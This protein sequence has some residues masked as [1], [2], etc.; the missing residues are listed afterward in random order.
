MGWYNTRRRREGFRDHHVGETMKDMSIEEAKEKL[1]PSEY[2]KW[3]HRK[4]EKVL[5]RAEKHKE[6][7][8]DEHEQATN[9]LIDAGKSALTTTCT[10]EGVDFELD[11]SFKDELQDKLKRLAELSKSEPS[12]KTLKKIRWDLINILDSITLNY[13]KEQWVKFYKANGLGGL[14]LFAGLMFKHI[15]QELKAK[16]DVVQ[17]FRTPQLESDL[18]TGDDEHDDERLVELE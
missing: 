2:S 17:N 10:I 18:S 8:S 3:K 4:E 5:K 15:R 11:M 13:D 12:D 6:Q 14:N 9:D 7:I 1:S 16:V